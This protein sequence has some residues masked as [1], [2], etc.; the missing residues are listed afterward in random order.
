MS[1]KNKAVKGVMWNTIERFSSQGIQFVLTIVIARLLSPSDYGLIA[2]LS[3]FMAIAQTMIDSGLY[4]A[5][6]QKQDRTETDYNTM[7]YFNF[8]VSAI[9]YLLLFVSAPLIASFYEQPLLVKI[10]RVYCLVLV[11]NSLGVIQVARLTIALDFKKQMIATLSSVVVGG[12]LGLGMAYSGFGVWT[13]V[14]QNLIGN[15]TWVFVLWYYTRWRPGWEF[16]WTSFRS[17]FSFGSRLLIASMLNTLYTNMY[18]LVIGKYFNASTLGY[19]NRSYTLG[20]FPVQNFGNVVQKVLY[21]IQC[22]YQNDN[23]KFNQIF[24]TYLRLSGFILFPLMIGLAVLS[25]PIITL[26]LTDKWLPAASLFQILC[27]AFMWFPTM[28][29]NVSVLDAKGR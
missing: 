16:S 5:L 1:V 20:Q 10:I 23:D 19:F 27:L 2:M 4:N 15:L 29:A 24:I 28:Q 22:K 13:L 8:V 6:I 12:G 9:I 7:F 17:L 18:S 26:L 25:A 11:T 3:I 21:P 14:F